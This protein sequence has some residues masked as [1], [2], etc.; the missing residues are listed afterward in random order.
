[1]CK[2]QVYD[3]KPT[4]FSNTLWQSK[5]KKLAK[6][7]STRG[8]K[9]SIETEMEIEGSAAI[10]SATASHKHKG[11]ALRYTAITSMKIWRAWTSYQ[12]PKTSFE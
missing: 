2:W 9:M 6:A 3:P 1:M 11:E 10:K 8:I 4:F 12:K 5:K 7:T